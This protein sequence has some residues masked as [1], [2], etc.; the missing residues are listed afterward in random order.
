M[1]RRF[2]QSINFKSV[3]NLKSEL[4]FVNKAWDILDKRNDYPLFGN[5]LYCQGLLPFAP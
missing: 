2:H 4:K 1:L 5:S 3:L